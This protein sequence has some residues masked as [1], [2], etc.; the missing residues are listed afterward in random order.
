MARPDRER[1]VR[2]RVP[3]LLATLAVVAAAAGVYFARPSPATGQDKM[4]A[5]DNGTVPPVVPAEKPKTMP[6]DVVP[7]EAAPA[8]AP[9]PAP[10]KKDDDSWKPEKREW[11]L[12]PY[13]PPKGKTPTPPLG[14]PQGPIAAP[15]KAPVPG[16]RV[17]KWEGSEREPFPMPAELIGV[18]LMKQTQAEATAKSQ[19]CTS[20]HQGVGDMHVKTT[21]H[22]G[23]VDCHG[24]DA[25]KE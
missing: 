22:L 12:T 3:L 15:E 8:P 19:A 23:C 5:A 1:R 14:G 9:A 16:E 17:I 13:A 20:C 18:D 21:V 6:A 2:R 10:M 24:G 4:P 25:H 11:Y 7:A